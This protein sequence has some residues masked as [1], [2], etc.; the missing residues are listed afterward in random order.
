MVQKN[1]KN[2]L[3]N[4]RVVVA[5]VVIVTVWSHK[6]VVVLDLVLVQYVV[7]VVLNEPS[8]VLVV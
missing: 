2:H 7:P 3:K 4:G 5:S 8:V 6:Q 1:L